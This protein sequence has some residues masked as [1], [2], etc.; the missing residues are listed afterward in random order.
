MKKWGVVLVLAGMLLAW[1]GLAGRATGSL[2][3]KKTL[4][5]PQARVIAADF[6][7][8]HFHRLQLSP[9]QQGVPTVWP[10]LNFGMLRLWDSGTRWADIE[11]TRGDWRFGRL[12][13]YVNEAGVHGAKVLYTLGST[14]KW[15][16]ARPEERCGYYPHGCA[17][18][19]R[20]MED[21]REYV[22]VVARRYR[23]K[24][25]CYEVWNEP[26]FSGPSKDP[27]K[28][29]FYTGSVADL[30]EM[31]RIARQVLHEEDPDAVLFSPAIVNGPLN[32]LDK[33]LAAGGRDYVQ[34]ISYHFYA[35]NDE[36]R[37]LREIEAVRDVMRK[38]G[39]AHLPLWSTE[40]GVEVYAP[41]EP[42]P[43]DIKTRIT[44][45]EAA[46]MMVRQIALAAF[47]GLDKY[48]Y[49]AWDSDKSGMV[50][51]AGQPHPSRDAMLLVQRWLI[52]ATPDHCEIQD[53]QPTVC[54]GEKDT[55][56]FAIVW[57]PTTANAVEV[58]VPAGLRITTRQVAVPRWVAASQDVVG[59]RSMLATQNPAFYT[60]E[61]IT[62]Q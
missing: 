30:V 44:R 58:P 18:E 47:A 19:P 48:F 32:R 1:I 20:S 28:S 17:A 27:K 31:A 61:R 24:I 53:G 21:W 7:G 13:Y 25:C 45:E 2:A 33:F 3:D 51:R 46:A 10:P 35:F 43:P 23:G 15:A 50:D 55:K 40:A 14:P 8:I 62:P 57:N 52:G 49:Y 39:L 38:N 36:S 12:D 41:N 29:A 9:N 34:G 5:P 6:F 59:A 22:R 42:M 56:P 37:M 4:S 60:F 54:W 16:S 26:D 11:P